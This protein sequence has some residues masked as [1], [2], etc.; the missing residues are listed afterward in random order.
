MEEKEKRLGVGFQLNFVIST[1]K[2][3]TR[4]TQNYTTVVNITMN[5]LTMWAWCGLSTVFCYFHARAKYKIYK[6]YTTVVNIMTTWHTSVTITG[7]A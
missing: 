3:N 1:C 7:N 2:P 4:C 5:L 6:N